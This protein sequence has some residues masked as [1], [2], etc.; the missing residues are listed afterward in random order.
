[1]LFYLYARLNNDLLKHK[2]LKQETLESKNF[3]SDGTFSL[4]GDEP[5]MIASSVFNSFFTVAACFSRSAL[6]SPEYWTFSSLAA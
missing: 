6:I 5:L 4:L 2:E 1:M 3:K